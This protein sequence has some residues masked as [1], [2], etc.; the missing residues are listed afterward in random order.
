MS[1][2]RNI[3]T[4]QTGCFTSIIKERICVFHRLSSG[5]FGLIYIKV[6]FSLKTNNPFPWKMNWSIVS[7]SSPL[8]S[9]I[10][11]EKENVKQKYC[12]DWGCRQ[13][14]KTD[15]SRWQLRVSGCEVGLSVLMTALPRPLWGGQLLLL[16]CPGLP[17]L[18]PGHLPAS[19]GPDLLLVLPPQ[20]HHRHL[21]GL[22]PRQLQAHGLPPP[23]P[24]RPRHPPVAQLPGGSARQHQLSLEGGA[25]PRGQ[26]PPHHPGPLAAPGLLAH[27][28]C[29]E[30]PR[31]HLHLLPVHGGAAPPH[32]PGQ[33]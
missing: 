18:W 12:S 3:T 6:D 27:P 1:N 30:G 13:Q 24:A 15:A 8:W 23:Q 33:G 2:F 21:G 14:R 22:L 17:A 16:L 5:R 10:I 7:F 32:L 26:R 28:D 31:H 29:Q 20:H 11:N 9:I 4:T 25:R 19:V